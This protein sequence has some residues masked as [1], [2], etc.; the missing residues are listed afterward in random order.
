MVSARTKRFPRTV[1]KRGQYV[2]TLI[3]GKSGAAVQT[4]NAALADEQQD[5]LER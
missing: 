4:G 2:H 5:Q 3:T 1:N